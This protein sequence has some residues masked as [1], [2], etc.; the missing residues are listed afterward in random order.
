MCLNYYKIHVFTLYPLMY[1]NTNLYHADSVSPGVKFTHIY[2]A[3]LEATEGIS[4][5]LSNHW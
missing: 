2:Q 3:S 5:L 1:F 4:T